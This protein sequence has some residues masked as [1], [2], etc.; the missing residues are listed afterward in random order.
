M[1]SASKQR[2]QSQVG[3]ELAPSTVTQHSE[4]HSQLLSEA[5][6]AHTQGVLSSSRLV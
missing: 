3:M 6:M 5:D 4:L 1:V 2:E